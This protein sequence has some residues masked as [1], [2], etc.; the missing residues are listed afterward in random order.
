MKAVSCIHIICIFMVSLLMNIGQI[1]GLIIRLFNWKLGTQ[2]INGV[3][4]CFGHFLVAYCEIY[5]GLRIYI[6]NANVL[7]QL[8]NSGKSA[9]ITCNHISYV[10]WV[11]LF[12]L[13]ARFGMI[14]G[15]KIASKRVAA[16]MPGMGWAM[17]LS[18]YPLINKS[19]YTDKTTLE[20]IC[21][22]YANMHV[23]GMPVY[24]FIFPEGTF[25]DNHLDKNI[26]QTRSF[27][28]ANK[29]PSYNRVLCPRVK[30][31]E[32]LID[33]L[34]KDIPDLVTLDITLQ[35]RSPYNTYL[36]LDSQDRVVPNIY[37]FFESPII[38]DVY[39]SIRYLEGS[40]YNVFKTKDN[41]LA[42]EP[43]GVLYG[44]SNGETITALCVSSVWVILTMMMLYKF[45]I[46]L[47][48]AV[49]GLIMNVIMN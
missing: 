3:T 36:P 38:R 2:V 40:L 8:A 27:C 24:I 21:K 6:D 44:L 35:F 42:S 13:C 11:V 48:T 10:D 39:M 14:Y 49:I 20:E 1:I 4:G 7:E 32:F 46:I 15:I 9:I 41:D 30:G 16:M 33:E 12:M 29:L 37:N 5:P 43:H 17:Y 18:D 31:T 26:E 25:C 45:P 23:N 47:I 22:R 19:W 34:R 28:E